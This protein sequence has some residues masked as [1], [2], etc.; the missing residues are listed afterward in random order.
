MICGDYEAKIYNCYE[1]FI[2][3]NG[4][5]DEGGFTEENIK[6]SMKYFEK[7]RII[8][9]LLGMKEDA[10]EMENQLVKRRVGLSYF[11]ECDNSMSPSDLVEMRRFDYERLKTRDFSSEQTIFMGIEYA[12]ALMYANHTIEAERLIMKLASTSHR[13]HGQDHNC[14]QCVLAKFEEC[15]KRKVSVPKYKFLRFEAV[16]YEEWPHGREYC[17][18]KVVDDDDDDDDDKPRLP[19]DKRLSTCTIDQVLPN[20]GCPVMCVGLVREAHLNHEVGD[21]RAIL[22]TKKGVRVVVHFKKK[23]LSPAK[24]RLENLRVAFQLPTEGLENGLRFKVGDKVQAQVGGFVDG[25]IIKL[26]DFGNPYRIELED[27][28]KTN[29]WGPKDEDYYVRKRPTL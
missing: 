16:R 28:E 3:L 21:V 1:C 27:D 18:V 8:Y 12:G 2:T 20:I 10:K 15:R 7:A 22:K 17:V 9:S 5:D 13:V 25:V 29:V 23:S 6:L 26:W 24:L 14:T 4:E 11:N 19:D